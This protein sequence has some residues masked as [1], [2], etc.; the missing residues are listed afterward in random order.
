[1]TQYRVPQ[2]DIQFVL[3]EVWQAQQQW[4]AM[5]ALADMDTDTANAIIEEG[6]KLAEE[7]LFPINRS[8]DEEGCVFNASEHSVKTPTGFKAAYQQL[9]QGGWLS[10]G[11]QVDYG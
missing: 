9:A 8:G 10:L 7:V 1:M 5:P 3:H 4:Q 2:R 11:G 6:A